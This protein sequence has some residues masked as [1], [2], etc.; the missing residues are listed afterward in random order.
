MKLSGSACLSFIFFFP[1]NL[2]S[3]YRIFEME[4]VSL[5]FFFKFSFPF[6]PLFAVFFV[7]L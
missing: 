1:G 7:F 3:L 2:A 5:F 6:S 4:M